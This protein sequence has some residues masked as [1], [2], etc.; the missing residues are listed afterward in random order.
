[1][2]A[3]L[4]SETKT[5]GEE[6]I[7]LEQ[8]VG[9]GILK[10][11]DRDKLSICPKCAG[12]SHNIRKACTK[13]GS[14]SITNEDVIHHYP[15]GGVFIEQDGVRDGGVWCTKCKKKLIHIGVD[16]DRPAS[17]DKCVE[18][19]STAEAFPSQVICLTCYNKFSLN[20]ASEIVIHDYEMVD[21]DLSRIRAKLLDHESEAMIDSAS[22]KA[23]LRSEQKLTER[24]GREFSLLK[25]TCNGLSSD[26]YNQV[27][28]PKIIG[29][30]RKSDL[31][32]KASDTEF[33]ILLRETSKDCSEP[34]IK[35][36]QVLISAYKPSVKIE[37]NL[38]VET[39][40]LAKQPA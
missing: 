19:G 4:F 39:K 1:M 33:F 5:E 18:C 36:L 31:V 29:Q 30:L 22:F 24:H 35:R 3:S 14:V 13:C 8:L 37:S 27:L 21:M 9:Q 26:E 17:I 34:V 25:I 28:I 40:Q 6:R 11:I 32:T 15:C 12:V 38:P 2:A 7:L 16:F 10:R 20:E 23:V